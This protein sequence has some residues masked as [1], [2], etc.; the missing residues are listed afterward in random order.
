[1]E[2]KPIRVLLVEDNPGDFRLIQEMF[3]ESKATIELKW[4]GQ[5]ST[6]LANLKEEMFDVVLAD[7]GLPDS[8]GIDTF[9][10][11]H[12]QALQT[13]IVVLTG[14]DN[15]GLAMR[16]VR[17]GAQD[18]LVKGQIDSDLLLRSIRYAIE[19]YENLEQLRSAKVALALSE[20]RF[21]NMID[22]DADGILIVD[23]DGIVRFS[24]PG[25]EALWGR[26]AEELRGQLFGFPAV[27]GETTELDIIRKGGE[28]RAAEM[29]VV[30]MDWEGKSSCLA[31][32]RDIT[33]RKKAEEERKTM[34]LQLQNALEKV[35]TLSGLLPICSF[36]KKIRDDDGYWKKIETYIEAHSEAEFSHSLCQECARKHYPEIYKGKS[37]EL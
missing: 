11:I 30:E 32:V 2:E 4:T 34:I 31:S 7:L 36:C 3:K 1:M 19:R 28:T 35:K 13:P 24:N 21:R 37:E 26:K 20:A 22:R 9:K 5:L 23:G 16:A 12:D 17:E 27:A 10:K 29:R 6:G 14:L 8:Q 33:D 18:Y 25:A 15:N